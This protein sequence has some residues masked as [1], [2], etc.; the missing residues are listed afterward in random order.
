[1]AFVRKKKVKGKD[2]YQLVESRR[3]EGKPRQK[4]LAHLGQHASVDE[5][6]EE[7]PYEIRRLRRLATR[8][9]KAATDLPEGS[10]ARRAARRRAERAQKRTE[11][12]KA[13]LDELRRLRKQGVV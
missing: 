10:S 12:L 5:A 6:L 11:E 9:R 7:W 4:V 1:M 2:Y 13:N 3:V 8:Q